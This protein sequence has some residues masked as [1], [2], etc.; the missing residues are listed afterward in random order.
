MFLGKAK[1]ILLLNLFDV[2]LSLSKRHEV[3]PPRS[4]KL[5]YHFKREILKI[6][7]IKCPPKSSPQGD[8]N[9]NPKT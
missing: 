9:N 4:T 1:G 8:V 2:R 6:K 3:S 7:V 5:P